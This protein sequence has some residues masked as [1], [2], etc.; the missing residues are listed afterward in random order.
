MPAMHEHVEQRTREKQKIKND[1]KHVSGMPREKQ[2]QE[3]RKHQN[4]H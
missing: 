3:S 4:D 1:G 2:K